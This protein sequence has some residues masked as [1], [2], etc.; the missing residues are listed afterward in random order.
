VVNLPP[1]GMPHVFKDR[2]QEMEALHDYLGDDRVRLIR[3]VG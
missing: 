1:W 2:Q 3:I